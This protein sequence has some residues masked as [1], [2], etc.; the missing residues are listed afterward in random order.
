MKLLQG[1]QLS[2][3][4][5]LDEQKQNILVNTLRAGDII[6]DEQVQDVISALDQILFPIVVKIL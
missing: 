3:R 6:G 1:R 4:D 2:E 5:F